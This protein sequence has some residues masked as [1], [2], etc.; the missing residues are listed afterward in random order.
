MATL[1]NSKV[2]SSR[3]DLDKKGS[4]PNPLLA[5][6]IAKI[7]ADV[8]QTKNQRMSMNAAGLPGEEFPEDQAMAMRAAGVNLAEPPAQDIP[9]EP[10]AGDELLK[11]QAPEAPEVSTPNFWDK[12]VMDFKMGKN[13]TGLGN[14]VADAAAPVTKTAS[15]A[16]NAV[17]TAVHGVT[18]PILTNPFVSQ[19][20]NAYGQA[21]STSQMGP[22]TQQLYQL[23]GGVTGNPMPNIYGGA[24]GG[25]QD[26]FKGSHQSPTDFDEAINSA[27]ARVRALALTANQSPQQKALYDSAVESY[28]Q[29]LGQREFTL[30][31]RQGA[32]SGSPADVANYRAAGRSA[33]AIQSALGNLTNAIKGQNPQEMEGALDELVKQGNLGEDIKRMPGGAGLL[34][35]ASE[36]TLL[37]Y[38]SDPAN[39]AV[40]STIKGKLRAAFK[41]AQIEAGNVERLGNQI[42]NVPKDERGNYD[43]NSTEYLLAKSLAP[44][45]GENM[46]EKD[47]DAAVDALGTGE[48]NFEQQGLKQ[49]AD[50]GAATGASSIAG[51]EQYLAGALKEV[52]PQTVKALNTIKP[53]LGDRVQKA[54]VGN[55]S[56]SNKSFPPTTPLP[57]GLAGKITPA[58]WVEILNSK[59]PDDIAFVNKWMNR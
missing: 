9:T 37:K 12:L 58:K 1:D 4:P 10:P 49:A 50:T 52:G 44:T 13:G 38:L 18:A 43:T 46:D 42:Y 16:L 6:N 8:N 28:K 45:F 41:N 59:D 53:G 26:L 14:A 32:G 56:K 34:T 33:Q 15:N 36:G 3:D 11:E 29:L 22:A 24:A 57:A 48:N 23:I 25:N 19:I 2:S 30:S 20:L 40:A 21:A 47:F 54:F 17:G 31:T 39:V 5:P 7:A 55:A 27:A 51:T 35:A